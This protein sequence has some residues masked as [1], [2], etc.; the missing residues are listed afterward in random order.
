[1]TK[2]ELLK[3]IIKAK[4]HKEKARKKTADEWEREGI[5]GNVILV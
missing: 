4:E 5:E 1:M 3:A 2:E